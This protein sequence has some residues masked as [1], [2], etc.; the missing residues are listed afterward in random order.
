MGID[1][2]KLIEQEP[3]FRQF[4]ADVIIDV[5]AKTQPDF[6]AFIKSMYDIGNTPKDVA[7]VLENMIIQQNGGGQK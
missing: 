2:R 4:C 5:F 1:Y 7:R 3:E 6:I